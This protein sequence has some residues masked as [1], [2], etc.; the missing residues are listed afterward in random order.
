[1]L[2][3]QLGLYS[4]FIIGFPFY[5]GFFSSWTEQK[6]YFLVFSYYFYKCCCE[7]IDMITKVHVWSQNCQHTCGM[8]LC[9][10]Y[11]LLQFYFSWTLNTKCTC[12]MLNDLI[13]FTCIYYLI[14]FFK[15]PHILLKN[16]A[17]H[18]CRIKTIY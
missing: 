14:F 5:H 8:L 1:M 10:Q 11:Y 9:E 16:N 15:W 3:I 4:K 17:W 13:H 18:T 12:N 2:V 7:N 6:K